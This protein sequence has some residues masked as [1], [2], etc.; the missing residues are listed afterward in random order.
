MQRYFLQREM[1]MPDR[2][3]VLTSCCRAKSC[4]GKL[5][6]WAWIKLNINIAIWF[7]QNSLTLTR[8]SFS[9]KSLTRCSFKKYNNLT[10]VLNFIFLVIEIYGVVPKQNKNPVRLNVFIQST[11]LTY[12]SS[13]SNYWSNHLLR[14]VETALICYFF[15]TFTYNIASTNQHIVLLSISDIMTWLENVEIKLVTGAVEVLFLSKYS[16]TSIRKWTIT[17]TEVSRMQTYVCADLK[18][19]SNKKCNCLM[20]MYFKLFLFQQRGTKIM[21]VNQYWLA[22]RIRIVVVLCSVACS[23]REI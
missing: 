15:V 3:I 23:T 14:A 4:R 20:K 9:I 6:K 13:Y 5:P 22:H 7:N 16:I 11:W 12:L 2:T 8:Q 1:R 18:R 21:I 17:I 10:T 19:F